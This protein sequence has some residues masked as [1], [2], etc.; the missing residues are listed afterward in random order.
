MKGVIANATSATL[1]ENKNPMITP[2]TRPNNPSAIAAIASELAPLSVY[3]SE[4]RIA[5]RTP[6]ALS[7]LSCQPICF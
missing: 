1:Q 4:A 3:T 7:E 6:G 2:H 5:L